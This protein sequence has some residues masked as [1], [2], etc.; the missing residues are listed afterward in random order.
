M[1]FKNMDRDAL[2]Q[3]IVMIVAFVGGVDA[4]ALYSLKRSQLRPNLKVLWAF[5]IVLIPAVGALAFFF[6]R[7][8]CCHAGQGVLDDDAPVSEL[9]SGES[10]S[11]ASASGASGEPT[12]PR[13]LKE[14]SLGAGKESPTAAGAAR[15][16]WEYAPS[17]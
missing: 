8:S 10:A 16:K 12:T 11:P 15:R 2:I 4:C 6:L 7:P 3:N 13:L 9:A 14:L 17:S 1:D 5:I